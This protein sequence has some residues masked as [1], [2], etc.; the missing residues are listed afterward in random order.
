M[1]DIHAESSGSIYDITSTERSITSY[2]AESINKLE[3]H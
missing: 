1:F 2:I 3:A